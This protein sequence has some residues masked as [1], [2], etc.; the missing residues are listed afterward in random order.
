VSDACSLLHGDLGSA[1]VSGVSRKRKEKRAAKVRVRVSQKGD[2]IRVID[3]RAG[4]P[5]RPFRV[6]I[7]HMHYRRLSISS[8]STLLPTGSLALTSPCWCF[9]LPDVV[10]MNMTCSS[11][12][13][14]AQAKPGM[15]STFH[16]YASLTPVLSES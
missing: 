1:T 7:Q 8:Y 11:A 15:D 3:H 2:L 5:L 4:E 12:L 13:G 6:S 14:N 10:L 9:I 16:Y